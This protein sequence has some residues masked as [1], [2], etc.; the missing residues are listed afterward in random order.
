MGHCVVAYSV[1]ALCYNLESRGFDSRRGVLIIQ[2]TKS[3]HLHHGPWARL[4]T[5]NLLRIEGRPAR[6]AGLTSV[7]EPIF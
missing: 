2:L 6:K 5:N 1:E 3:F 7:C 4:S